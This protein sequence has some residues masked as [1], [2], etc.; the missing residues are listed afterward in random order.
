V[1]QPVFSPDGATLYTA[2]DDGTVIAWDLDGSRRLGRPFRFTHDRAPDPLFDRHPGSFSPDGR[3]IAAGLAKRGIQL[4]STT[5]LARAGA[6]LLQTGGEVKALAF[7]PGGRALAAVTR[8]GRATVWD[9]KARSLTTGPFRVDVSQALGVSFSADGTMLAT[10]GSEGVRLWDAV[11]GAARGRLGEAS[12]AD[13][14][15]FS[16]TAPVV[17]LVR[18]GWLA[19]DNPGGIGTGEAVAEIW[20][21]GRRSRIATL[22]VNAGAPDRD[23]GLGQT[24]AFSPDGRLLVTAGDDPLVRI[25]EVGTGRLVR[26]LE[27]NVGG[28][29]RLEFSPDSRLL[30]VSGKPDASLWDVETG[31]QVGRLSGGSRRAML[32][33][34]PDGRLLLMT[35]GNGQGAVW[36][37]DPDSWKDRACALA[38]RTLTREEWKEFLPGRSYEP[39]CSA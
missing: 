4:W 25:W 34:S 37:I 32:D 13:D 11:T 22:H 29:L 30:A 39:A 38:N 8:D 10:A 28:V 31:T 23:E 6:P 35:N 36:D 12:A 9:V 20:D 5:D 16:P 21:V 15:A 33:L 3:L 19:G 24:L 26:E 17:A 2:S 27:Q 7:G 1:G 18:D 14:V